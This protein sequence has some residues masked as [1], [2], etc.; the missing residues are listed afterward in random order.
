[1]KEAGLILLQTIPETIDIEI[2]KSNLMKKFV[3]INGVHDLHIW[4]LTRSK[5]V[6]TV[7][8]IFQDP[9]VYARIIDDI[10]VFFHEQGITI[11]TIQPEFQITGNVEIQ[12]CLVKCVEKACIL[13]HCCNTNMDLKMV[14]CEGGKDHHH[15]H[16]H[17]HGHSHSHKDTEQ[18]K[19]IE[20]TLELSKSS[21]SLNIPA[22]KKTEIIDEEEL[23]LNERK[24][25]SD[26]QVNIPEIRIIS[27]IEPEMNLEME[28]D[29]DK[30]GTVESEE[31][32]KHSDEKKVQLNNDKKSDDE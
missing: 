24:Y 7:H 14:K 23:P 20:T 18:L 9:D 13:K 28:D 27:D 22:L 32:I 30:V 31:V 4:Q 10:V 12:D 5:Y 17:G 2:F 26:T 25:A 29:I 16:G 15:G 1:M 21:Q 6:S 3:E 8:V 11:V 19:P